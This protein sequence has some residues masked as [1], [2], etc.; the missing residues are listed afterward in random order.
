[1]YRNI[2]T[3]C[4]CQEKKS[5]QR[6]PNVKRQLTAVFDLATTPL[7]LHG[8][9]P[10]QLQHPH[11]AKTPRIDSGIQWRSPLLSS[12]CPPL[13]LP[14]FLPLLRVRFTACRGR[15]A[16]RPPN[17]PLSLPLAASPSGLGF[18][19]IASRPHAFRIA[20]VSAGW[21]LPIYRAPCLIC[22]LESSPVDFRCS[23][24]W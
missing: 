1:M 13:S 23:I 8:Q 16:L 7:P 15:E 3:L 6:R 9:E 14:L 20:G 11:G 17:R 4:R 22:A 18:I 19:P 12:L 2:L 24:R 21:C 5:S 10:I